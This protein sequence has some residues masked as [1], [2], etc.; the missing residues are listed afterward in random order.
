MKRTPSKRS[1]SQTHPVLN[2]EI[3]GIAQYLSARSKRLGT[4]NRMSRKLKGV[5]FQISQKLNEKKWT[6]CIID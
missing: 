3:S 4:T 6:I 5:A 2:L 1:S